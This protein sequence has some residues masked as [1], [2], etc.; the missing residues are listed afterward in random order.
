MS[1]FLKID[2]NKVIKAL[3][4]MLRKHKVVQLILFVFPNSKVQIV[5]I[6]DQIRFYA[7]ISEIGPRNALMFNEI[8]SEFVDLADIF[9]SGSPSEQ[10]FLDIGANYGMYSFF[11]VPIL[12]NAQYHLFDANLELC[13]LIARSAL[14]YEKTAIS[15]TN[16]CIT[17]REEGSSNLKIDPVNNGASYISNEFI[18]SDFAVPNITIDKYIHDNNVPEIFFSKM[19]IEGYEFNALKG[20][21]KQ[22]SGGHIKSIM[23]EVVT[24]HLERAHSTPIQVIELLQSYG[25]NVFHFRDHDFKGF[26]YNSFKV[27]YSKRE[28]YNFNGRKLNLAPVDIE[29]AKRENWTFGTDLLAV[30]QSLN[31]I[32]N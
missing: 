3:P 13:Q 19:D 28:A 23:L 30:H 10:T 2:L 27:P 6:S 16:A 1:Q 11:L 9:L 8:D 18:D 7:D 31:L 15:I 21:S 5:H 14:L 29:A 22:L 25:F 4:R 12:P 26:P 32:K 17:D 24:S 20:M